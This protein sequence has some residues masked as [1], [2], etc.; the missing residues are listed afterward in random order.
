MQDYSKYR[1]DKSSVYAR[2]GSSAARRQKKAAARSVSNSVRTATASTTR[3]MRRKGSAGR[4]DR[5]PV[6]SLPDFNRPSI[7]RVLRILLTLSAAGALAVVAFF[8]I[9]SM[10]ESDAF[11]VRR[12]EISG[13]QRLTKEEI[14]R[15][16]AIP[17]GANLLAIDMVTIAEQVTKH[18]WVARV[19]V[20]RSLPD[21]LFIRL[22]ERVPAMLLNADL[23]GGGNRL[24]L[25]DD[26][27]V[28]FKLKETGDPVDLPIVTGLSRADFAEAK[29]LNPQQLLDA[30]RV[31]ELVY[32]SGMDERSLSEIRSL[33]NGLL[34]IIFENPNLEVRIDASKLTQQMERLAQVMNLGLNGVV[35]L[36]LAYSDRAVVRLANYERP[37]KL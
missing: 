15:V 6:A 7:K 11:S 1:K 24:Y 26:Q 8:C 36:D 29:D 28:L 33:N 23:D 18:P 27:A 30:L 17:A 16:A 12:I 37:Q 19:T 25:V 35:A 14:A 13:E 2:F 5:V 20:S 32:Q 31:I 4:R 10:R 3:K 34:T 9:T 21:A 22:E